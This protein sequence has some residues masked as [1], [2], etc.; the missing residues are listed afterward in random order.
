MNNTDKAKVDAAR[1]M[2]LGKIE[3]EEV[4][5]LLD[6][7][8]AQ[9]VPIKEEIEEQIRK[10]YGDVDAYDIEKGTVIFDNYDDLGKNADIPDEMPED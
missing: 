2:L 4:A 10:T 6:M 8:V 9:I 5:M 1:R 7:P 3:V